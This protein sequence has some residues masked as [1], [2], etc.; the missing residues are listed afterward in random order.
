MLDNFWQSVGI[1][2][3]DVYVVEIIVGGRL[4]IWRLRLS[5]FQKITVVLETCYLH[6][7]Y[8][9]LIRL[10]KNLPENI[11]CQNYQSKKNVHHE[12]KVTSFSLA[13]LLLSS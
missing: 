3:E 5:M 6:K 2:L 10:S 4:L 12:K 13:N 11:C 8:N 9:N 1:I 7:K